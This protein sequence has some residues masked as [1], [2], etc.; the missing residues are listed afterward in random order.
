MRHILPTVITFKSACTGYV[1]LS[2]GAVLNDAATVGEQ[3]TSANIIDM[4]KDDS[5]KIAT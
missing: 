1:R 2:F 5:E 3:Y 4:N